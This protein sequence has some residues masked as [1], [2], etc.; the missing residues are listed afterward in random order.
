MELLGSVSLCRVGVTIDA[1]PAILPVGFVLSGDLLLIGSAGGPTLRAALS[2]AV[3]AVE[4]D[5]IDEADHSGWSVLVR[6]R[7]FEV[8][9]PAQIAAATALGLPG[10]SGDAG[11]LV[12]VH[13]HSVSGRRIAPS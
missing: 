6:G 10:S 11:H 4:A 13:A 5:R 3:L 8:T 1:L 9:D 12:A 2:D 7:S